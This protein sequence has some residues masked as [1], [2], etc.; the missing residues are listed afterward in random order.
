[1]NKDYSLNA[2]L[3]IIVFWSNLLIGGN[4][5]LSLKR[6]GQIQLNWVLVY[7]YPIAKFRYE[8]RSKS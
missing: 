4:F 1:M 7:L 3:I 2:H 6:I 5:R 8:N